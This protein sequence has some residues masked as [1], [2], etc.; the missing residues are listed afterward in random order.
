[1]LQRTAKM[2]I[3]EEKV[4]LAS[5]SIGIT[6]DRYGLYSYGIRV[7][8][9]DS[10]WADMLARRIIYDGTVVR[11]FVLHLFFSRS[12]RHLTAISTNKL[13]MSQR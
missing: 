2:D 8:N 4:Y 7:P 13:I 6:W 5:M 3:S 11:P 9:K 12:S 10:A 1:M